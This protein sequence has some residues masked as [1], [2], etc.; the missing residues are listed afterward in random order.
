M[1]IISHDTGW[2]KRSADAFICQKRSTLVRIELGI[3]QYGSQEKSQHAMFLK[4]SRLL[5]NCRDFLKTID[6]SF[7]LSRFQKLARFWKLSQSFLHTCLSKRWEIKMER[8]KY[9]FNY[10]QMDM[11]VSVLF[12]KAWNFRTLR[13]WSQRQHGS[14]QETNLDSFA[15]A[16][17]NN[18]QHVLKDISRWLQ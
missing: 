10:I 9:Q 7:K 18:M 3:K 6:I 5:S 8:A 1:Q 16:W 2:P 12:R 17:K 13:P 14:F 15:R 11:R 4:L